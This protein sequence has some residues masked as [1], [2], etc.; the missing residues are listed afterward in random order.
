MSP[1][2]PKFTKCI[3]AKVK[4]A[5]EP[6]K[7][8][9]KPKTSDYLKQCQQEY[10]Q[11]KQQVMTFLIRSTWLEAEADKLGVKVSDEGGQGRVREGAQAGLPEDRRLREVP[12]DV[13]PDRG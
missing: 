6:V 13:R 10:D 4:A 12:Q 9:P 11:L 7:G 1:D 8:Q 5:P 3:A 2:P